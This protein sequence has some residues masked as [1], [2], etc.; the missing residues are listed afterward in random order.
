[1]ETTTSTTH[2]NETNVFLNTPPRD[3]R[4]ARLTPERREL[5]DRILKRRERIGVVEHDLVASLMDL[6]DHG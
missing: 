4:I 6:R 5:Y 3:E 1:M 2:P